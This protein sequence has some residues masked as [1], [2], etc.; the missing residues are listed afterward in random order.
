MTTSTLR[1]RASLAWHVLRGNVR[2]S[3]QAKGS[4]FQFIWPN[5]AGEQPLWREYDYRTLVLEGYNANA[6]IRAAIEYKM[7][8]ASMAPLRAWTGTREQREPADPA[9]PL[10][11]LVSRPNKYQSAVE[12]SDLNTGYL[13]LAGNVYIVLDRPSPK[14][15]PTAMYTL[16][17]DRVRIIP[18]PLNKNEIVGY[19]YTPEGALPQYGIPIL[20]QDMMHVKRVNLL[21]PL[22]GLGEGTPPVSSSARSVDVD[23]AVTRFLDIF[24]KK[25]AM[26]PAMLTADVPL[27][28]PTIARFKDRWMELYGGYENWTEPMVVGGQGLKYQRLGLSFEEMGFEGIDERNETRTLMTIGVP[29]VLVGAR[30]GLKMS[31]D[32]AAFEGLRKTFWEDRFIPE[33]MRFEGDYAYHLQGDDGVF[34][35]YDFSRVPALALNVLELTKSA[36]DLWGMGVPANQAISSVGLA[37]VGEVP[38]GDV[39]YLPLS[40][41]PSGASF[42]EEPTEEEA[43]V[44]TEEERKFWA[45]R[46]KKKWDDERKQRLGQQVERIAGSWVPKFAGATERSMRID[47]RALLAL[48]TKE[49]RRAIERKQTINW[50]EVGLDWDAYLAG[51]A[52]ENWQETFFPF[53]F[54]VIEDQGDMWLESTGLGVRFDLRSVPSEEWFLDYTLKFAQPIMDTTKDDIHLLVSQALK[55]GFSVPQMEEQLELIFDRYLDP[56]FTL[57]GRRLTDEEK[58]WFVDRSPRFRRENIS[59]TETLRSSNSG[60]HQLFTEWGVPQKEWLAFIDN[61]TRDSHKDTN[62]QVRNIDTPFNVGGESSAILMMHPHDMSINAGL[63]EVAQCRCVELPVIPERI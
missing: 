17:P 4:A 23:N 31:N 53:I 38:G 47:E 2:N 58:Q 46:A 16:R 19:F 30:V 44:A 14:E 57:E 41:V 24:F 52:L 63:D 48:I 51:P 5:L 36:V 6:L 39:G 33:L 20:A 60:S 29:A 45:D 56:N 9:H 62:G 13:S 54:G 11:Q 55:E 1:H 3:T 61:R 21:D 26:P 37:T 42:S 34:V 18:S 22:D 25:G 35:A 27:D 15:F 59:R 43:P 8:A 40:L 7:D 32:R 28:D 49:K 50:T 12:F 10:S